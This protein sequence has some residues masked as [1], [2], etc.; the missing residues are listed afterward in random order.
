VL[1]Q[2]SVYGSDNSCLQAALGALGPGRA[3]GVA[4][5]C[6]EGPD[7]ATLDALHAVGVRGVRL[8]IE[9][10]AGATPLRER[11]R[12]LGWLRRRQGWCLQ[13]H[14]STGLLVPALDALVAL[15][16]PVVL[17]H[18]AGLHKQPLAELEGALAPIREFLASGPG[19]AK[20]S[21]PYRRH[22]SWRDADIAR[23]AAD[24]ADAAPTRLL[25]GS[26]WPH[27]GGEAGRPRDPTQIEPFREIDNQAVLQQ[28][29]QALGESSWRLM[30]QD[31]PQALY[32]FD[33]CEGKKY[34]ETP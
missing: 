19:Y 20:L 33:P 17:D 12:A 23:L 32:G 10:A 4:V 26:D 22:P 1:V 31:N 21:A 30:L 8:N 16:V 15:G 3:R 29:R 27:T 28:L 9:V 14:A 2:P 11:V 13:L 6:D 7:E 25:W 5:V 18:Y 34:E 24:L